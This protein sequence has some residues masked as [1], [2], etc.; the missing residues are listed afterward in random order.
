MGS[1]KSRAKIGRRTMLS[2]AAAAA[3]EAGLRVRVVRRDSVPR[4]GPMG[5][6]VTALRRSRAEVVVFLSCDMP[7]VRPALLRRVAA[8]VRGKALAAFVEI[9][10][11]AGFP[12]AMRRAALGFAEELILRGE[13]SLQA[14][15]RVTLS[16][17]LRPGAAFH[18]ALMNVNTRSD[19]LRA[20]K[21]A[22]SR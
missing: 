8:A 12:F 14:L 1:D 19:L 5:G 17:R 11:T 2:L 9:S 6:V 15:A 20:R 18:R 13:F 3:K 7:F 22:V 21:R 10:G 16:R 4:C